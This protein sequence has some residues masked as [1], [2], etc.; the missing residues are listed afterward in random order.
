MAVDVSL[1]VPLVVPGEPF[2]R[3]LESRFG[4]V[5][6]ATE[7]VGRL[8][9]DDVTSYED[10]VT[11]FSFEVQ[12]VARDALLSACAEAKQCFGVESVY[13]RCAGVEELI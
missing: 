5:T 8:W 4:V 7:I 11:V 9:S 12:S 13:L 1:V 3:L 6:V 2:M 10:E